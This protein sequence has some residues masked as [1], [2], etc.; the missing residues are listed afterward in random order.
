MLSSVIHGSN[1]NEPPVRHL[2][3]LLQQSPDNLG[4]AVTGYPLMAVN[5]RRPWTP[6]VLLVSPEGQI[7]IFDLATGRKAG[8]HV[9]RL[10]LGANLVMGKLRLN[11]RAR[12]RRQLIIDVSTVTFGPNV[13]RTCPEHPETPIVNESQLLDKVAQL[14]QRQRELHPDAGLDDEK[15][16]SILCDYRHN[17]GE[18]E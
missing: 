4:Q 1:Y 13:V 3:E 15:V 8:D 2:V 16:M 18:P 12:H 10:D 9:E 17:W 14:Q 7:I 5:D 6:D 11:P